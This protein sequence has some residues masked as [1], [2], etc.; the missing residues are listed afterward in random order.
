MKLD[1]FFNGLRYQTDESLIPNSKETAISKDRQ[2]RKQLLINRATRLRFKFFLSKKWRKSWTICPQRN[3]LRILKFLSCSRGRL[4]LTIGKKRHNEPVVRHAYW[5]PICKIKPFEQPEDVLKEAA[6]SKWITSLC[7]VFC[8]C[9][10][11]H[12]YF[13]FLFSAEIQVN[14]LFHL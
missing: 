6:D 7:C 2:S 10:D 14:L 11:H 5:I 13:Y 4:L 1:T 9:I 3:Y 12:H 8:S